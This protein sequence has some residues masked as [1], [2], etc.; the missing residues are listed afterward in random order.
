MSEI[1]LPR[2]GFFLVRH[3]RLFQRRLDKVVKL[4]SGQSL[5]DDEFLQSAFPTTFQAFN[6]LPV[7]TFSFSGYPNQPRT[8]GVTLSYYFD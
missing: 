2:A 8:W 6:T 7:E 3:L 1:A 5:G 4:L